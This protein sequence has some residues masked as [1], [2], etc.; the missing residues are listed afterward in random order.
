MPNPTL[1]VHS[2][3]ASATKGQVINLALSTPREH[4]RSPGNVG[5]QKLELWDTNGRYRVGGGQFTINGVAQTGAHEI[6][7]TPAN[8]ANVVFDVGTVGWHRHAVCPAGAK[9]RP[10]VRLEGSSR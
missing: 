3:L 10:A 2:N 6:D 9:R 7:V 1:S 5:Y 8:V 4:R